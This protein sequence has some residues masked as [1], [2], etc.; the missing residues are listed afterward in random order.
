MNHLTHK[1]QVEI[2]APG[3]SEEGVYA[4]LNCGADAVYIGG[5][6][7][8]AR[9]YADNPDAGRLTELIKEVHL[10]GKKL[11]LTVNTLLKD[12]ELNHQLV[13]YLTPFYENGLDAVIVQ[14]FGV[15]QTVRKYFPDLALHASTQMTVVSPE[16][17]RFLKENGASRIVPA[18]E[19]SLDEIRKIKSSCDIEV[20]TFVHGALCYCYSGQCLMSSVIGGRSGNRGRCAQPCRLPYQFEASGKKVNKAD[21]SYMLSPKDICTLNIIPDLM[22]AGID[23]FKIEGRMKKPEY[24]ALVAMLYRKYADMYL[25]QGR[26]GFKVDAQDVMHLMDLY[27]RGGFTEGYY[28]QHNGKNMISLEKPNH[29]GTVAARIKK[30]TS[31]QIVLEALNTLEGQDILELSDG[32]ADTKPYQ[33]TLKDRILKNQQFKI[34]NIRSLKLQSGMLCYRTRNT[35]LIENVKKMAAS[36]QNKE[37]IYGHLKLF[38]DLPVTINV[39]YKDMMVEVC[40]PVV[41]P[42]VSRAM[43]EADIRKQICKTGSTPYVFDS[44]D[45]E[46]DSDIFIPVTALNQLRR[47]ALDALQTSILKKHQRRMIGS[48]FD[49]CEDEMLYKKDE[50]SGIKDA[51]PY[52]KDEI[53]D[54]KDTISYKKDAMP[55][56][57]VLT[58]RMDAT[59]QIIQKDYVSVIY[60]EY[61]TACNAGRSKVLALADAAHH[62]HQKLYLAL[63]HLIR[64]DGYFEKDRLCG[65]ADLMDGALVRSMEGLLLLKSVGYDK[66]IIADAR[67]YAWNQPARSFLHA[68]GISRLTMPE[69][70]N[71]KEMQAIDCRDLEMIVYGYRPLMISAQCLLKTSNACKKDSGHKLQ[72]PYA[73]QDRTGRKMRVVPHCEGC[74]NLIY[75]SQMLDLSGEMKSIRQLGLQS[76]RIE[77]PLM[78]ENPADILDRIYDSLNGGSINTV[79]VSD[80]TKGHFKRGVE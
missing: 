38:K 7:F 35:K 68:Q 61:Q 2:L 6:M 29:F 10:R 21:Q 23:S 51:A 34:K 33:W 26:R 13:P 25:E 47:E 28:G 24:A 74:Y 79:A 44:L 5:Q 52:K 45:I 54:T 80:F 65:M 49:V 42:A 16:F 41:Q 15:W 19:L 48:D 69:E 3:G 53:L 64:D 71:Y 77:L 40:G 58:D 20:E 12:K 72:A 62:N 37:K 76:I 75:N 32:R 43:T 22:D 1:N 30:V 56:I 60:L 9:A 18:R 59:V 73:L 8:G 17:T 4:A 66:D 50:M 39:T 67:V 78:Q 55:Q 36:A 31:D 27:N 63:P 14:D 57:N 11:Y 46:M 70:L